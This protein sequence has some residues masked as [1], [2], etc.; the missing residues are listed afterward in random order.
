MIKLRAFDAGA[1]DSLL[2]TSDSTAILIDGGESGAFDRHIAGQLREGPSLD[3]VVVTH[4]DGDHI[5]GIRNLYRQEN[6]SSVRAP[7]VRFNHFMPVAADPGS[8]QFG[9]APFSVEHGVNLVDLLRSEDV[10]VSGAS[11]GDSI[12]FSDV[13]LTVL[14]PD[15]ALLRAAEEEWNEEISAL[16]QGD[17]WSLAA[18]RSV[19][20]DDSPTNRASITTLVSEP[21]GPPLALLAGDALASDLL[22]QLVAAGLCEEGGSFHV[23]VLKVQHH[24]SERNISREFLQRVSTDHY[25]ISANGRHDN[26]DPSTLEMLIEAAVSTGATIWFTSDGRSASQQEKMGLARRRVAAANVPIGNAPGA[27]VEIVLSGG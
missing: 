6:L 16:P 9:V 22:D 25:I 3:L 8:P 14:G 23:P 2:L 24:G 26:P 1:G 10:E 7:A 18:M 21:D 20:A 5:L 4:W 27:P 11:A 13:V 15:E 17:G 12:V 19:Q